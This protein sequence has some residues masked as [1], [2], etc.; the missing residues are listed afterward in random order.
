MRRRLVA[1][2]LLALSGCVPASHGD[3]AARADAGP[4]ALPPMKIFASPQPAAP[5]ISNAD[6]TR[7][8]LDLMFKLE[9]GR[10][11]RVFTRFEGSVSLRVTG[12]VP[13]SLRPDLSRLLGRLRREA[14]INIRQTNDPRANITIEAVSGAAIRRNLPQA[15][16]FVVP[17]V[18]SLDE[19]NGAR[20]AGFTSWARL[21]TRTKLSIFVPSDAS[22]QELRDCLHEELAQ[23]LGPLNDLYRLPDSVFNDDNVHTVLTGYDMLILRIAYSSDLRSGMTRGEVAA[24]LPA[25][26]R[27]LNPAGDGQQASN[28]SETP[29]SWRK[30]IHTALGP[31][32]SPAGRR[33]AAQR[34]LNIAERAGWH[35][36]R[37]AFA[38]YALWRMLAPTDPQAAN[39][40][41]AQADALYARL[42]RTDLHRAYVAT[43]LAAYKITQGDAEAAELLIAPHIAT[44]SQYENATL[45]STLLLLQAEALDLRGQWAQARSVRLD[46]LGWARY[47]YGP[48]WAVRAKLEEVSALNPANG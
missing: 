5:A 9:S 1:L 43:Q 17:N 31:G 20:R 21:E 44:A 36:H 13:P 48:D 12:D 38:H 26:L 34:A 29:S 24:R 11:L 3:V 14:G 35:D 45:L 40:N 8:F 47:G 30:A 37:R 46:S 23:A 16:C 42:P 7:D 41:L 15:A 39:R 4:S 19:Y 2:L 28:L 32:T 33:N 10:D 18:S 6:L 27:R 22:P 25:I